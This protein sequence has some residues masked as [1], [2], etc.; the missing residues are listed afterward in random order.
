MTFYSV[1]RL[2]EKLCTSK[3]FKKPEIVT[4]SDNAP[5]VK[6]RPRDKVCQ[7]AHPGEAEQVSWITRGRSEFSGD[8]PHHRAALPRK[9]QISGCDRR[10][11][12]AIDRKRGAPGLSGQGGMET[13][14]TGPN[15]GDAGAEAVGLRH[16]T[17]D[18]VGG[19][20]QGASVFVSWIILHFALYSLQIWIAGENAKA[21]Y[22][23]LFCVRS[24]ST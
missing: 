2:A 16:H 24:I 9:R 13:G 7:G 19:A 8:L 1:I 12:A 17:R 11:L 10:L 6:S 23:R 15:S 4:V 5:I 21:V 14:R 18:R 3:S 20:G 22:Y